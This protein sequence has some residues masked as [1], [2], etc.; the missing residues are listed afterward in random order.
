VNVVLIFVFAEN[1]TKARHTAVKLVRLKVICDVIERHKNDIV[2]K[3]KENK[4]TGKLK[5]DDDG[6]FGKKL[7]RITKTPTVPVGEQKKK[8]FGK[9]IKKLHRLSILTIIHYQK[10][11]Q[12]EKKDFAI[13]VV[14]GE[15]Y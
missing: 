4:S 13:F 11:N 7:K 9:I 15:L 12:S 14:I 5:N 8:S 10:N 6:G 1:A 2:T 3:K